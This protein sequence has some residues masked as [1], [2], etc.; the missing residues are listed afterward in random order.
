MRND[1][2]GKRGKVMNAEIHF[3]IISGDKVADAKNVMLKSEQMLYIGM[4]YLGRK[5]DYG[6][7]VP[8]KAV[9]GL[10]ELIDDYV[11][12]AFENE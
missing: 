8:D 6:W 9:N 3:T 4:D 5:T 1:K 7:F 2:K 12:K 10:I 11:G